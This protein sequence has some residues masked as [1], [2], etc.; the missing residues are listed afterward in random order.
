MSTTGIWA[1]PIFIFAVMLAISVI[2]FLLYNLFYRIR[3]NRVLK[4]ETPPAGVVP[5]PRR[6]GKLIIILCTAAC[7]LGFLLWASA[8]QRSMAELNENMRSMMTEL[9]RK[10]DANYA[11]LVAR[12]RSENSL[13]AD[14]GWEVTEENVEQG[15]I[16]VAFHAE[17]K[18]SSESTKVSLS[19]GGQEVPLARSGENTYSGEFTADP[20]GEMK[21]VGVLSIDDEG[22][23]KTE[24]AEIDITPWRDKYFPVVG[25]WLEQE[26]CKLPSYPV[27]INE[28]TTE[29]CKQKLHALIMIENP[30]A[31]RSLSL[32]I[33]R[34]EEV[35]RE[36]PWNEMTVFAPWEVTEDSSLSFEIDLSGEYRLGKLIKIQLVYDD[37]HGF[38]HE[39]TFGR[40]LPDG[41]LSVG[42]PENIMDESGNVLGRIERPQN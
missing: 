42:S 2:A 12:L 19:I 36:I 35:L 13:F 3:L 18:A 9:N 40:L 17:P 16:T 7:I 33:S 37:S 21:L 31:M 20:F 39:Y 4:G 6:A 22:Y 34:G 41:D 26:E 5:E 24:K 8:L 14:Y 32:V 28:L 27:T 29:T 30:N 11:D 23:V 15:G 25:A 1:S 10:T 38:K